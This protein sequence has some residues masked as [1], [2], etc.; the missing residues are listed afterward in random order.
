MK[1]RQC[2]ENELKS[3]THRVTRLEKGL[4]R[5]DKLVMMLAQKFDA[6]WKGRHGTQKEDDAASGVPLH[7]EDR[8][9]EGSQE[10]D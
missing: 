5:H 7:K 9:R 3:V 2:L 6:I 8:I 1:N 10:S 4:H